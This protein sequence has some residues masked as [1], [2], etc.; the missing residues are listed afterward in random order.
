[1]LLEARIEAAIVATSAGDVSKQLGDRNVL[2]WS[3]HC[4]EYSRSEFYHLLLV[5]LETLSL[6][7]DPKLLHLIF[8]MPYWPFKASLRSCM[9]ICSTIEVL[10]LLI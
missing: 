1:M 7:K 2:N 10:L 8:H 9:A 5:V 4:P 3:R 6:A